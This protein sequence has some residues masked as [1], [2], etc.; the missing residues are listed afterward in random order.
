MKK[1]KH[2]FLI[3]IYCLL[4]IACKRERNCTDERADNFEEDR[5]STCDYSHADDWD[6]DI[7]VDSVL[8]NGVKIVLENENWYFR[9]SEHDENYVYGNGGI[10]YY[11]SEYNSIS[12]L[13]D[14]LESIACYF[15]IPIASDY[16][17]ETIEGNLF[18]IAS[19]DSLNNL[20]YYSR[21]E[22]VFKFMDERVVNGFN[23]RFYSIEIN[24]LANEEIIFKQDKRFLDIYISVIYDVFNANYSLDID[25]I[26]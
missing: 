10:S 14:T 3:I 2:I 16:E 4:I 18:R 5:K 23:Y 20:Q 1:Q 22:S 21:D 26:L 19:I 8:I 15:G 6:K 7:I 9:G 25:R 13:E 24:D 12:F 11:S 17:I